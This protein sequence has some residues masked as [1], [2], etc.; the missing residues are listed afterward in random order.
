MREGSPGAE[1]ARADFDVAKSGY[2]LA[3]LGLYALPLPS[4]RPGALEGMGQVPT[5]RGAPTSNQPANCKAPRTMRTALPC[6][7]K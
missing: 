7:S 3:A 2:V 6:H 4:G 5:A 1:R